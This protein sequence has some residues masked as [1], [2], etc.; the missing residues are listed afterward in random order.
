MHERKMI[1]WLPFNSV[2]NS[3]IL[4]KSIEYDKGKMAKPVLS[5]EQITRLEE[6]I[7]EAFINHI[8][9]T[10]VVYKGGYCY[11]LTGFISK[12]DRTN[13]KIILNYKQNVY[14]CEIIKILY[15]FEF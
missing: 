13:K 12:I 11:N 8:E 1:K 5:E 6:E 15:N 4:I 3:K 14:F 10:I 9:I 7:F 2:I